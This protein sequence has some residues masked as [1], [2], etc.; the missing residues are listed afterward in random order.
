MVFWEGVDTDASPIVSSASSSF[1]EEGFLSA[2]SGFSGGNFV[3]ASRFS[4]G[5]FVSSPCFSGKGFVSTL[6]V[7]L[8][9]SNLARYIGRTVFSQKSRHSCAV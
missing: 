8:A 9:L 4:G 2:S 7:L 6:R 1:L 3:S 5:S